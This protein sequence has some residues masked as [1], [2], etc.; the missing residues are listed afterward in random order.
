MNAKRRRFLFPLPIVIPVVLFWGFLEFAAAG[1]ER[2]RRAGCRSQLRTLAYGLHLYSSDFNEAFAE[3]FGV[4]YHQDYLKDSL[5]YLCPSA[6]KATRL[7]TDPRYSLFGDMNTDYVYVS[8]PRA[9]DPWPYVLAF[10]DECNHDGNG[11]NVMFIGG[12]VEWTRDIK[13]LH[14][15][16]ARQE[17]ELAA[18]GRE[19]KILRP[20]WSSWPEPPAGWRPWYMRPGTWPRAVA[21]SALTALVL[22]LILRAL[23][24]RA[25]SAGPPHAQE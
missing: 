18:K 9:N 3:S 25:P 8:G 21:A 23:R 15:Q 6:G 19:M 16:L 24:R 4:L 14:E 22:V 11:V 13:G 1:R 10:D 17:K 2:A 7:E 20:P 5:C 12:N